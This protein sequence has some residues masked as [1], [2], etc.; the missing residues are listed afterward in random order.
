MQKIM[1]VE[2]EDDIVTLLQYNLEREGFEVAAETNGGRAVDA[3]AVQQPDL[4]LLDWMLP[5]KSGIDICREIRESND[6]RNI[7][8]I[9]LTARGEEADKIEGL[10]I[11]AD[12][13]MTK[14]FSVPE[15]VA[16]IRALL[17][18][19]RPTAT[20]GVLEFEDV[21]MDLATCRVTRGN[22]FVHLGPTEF[23]LL[24]FLMEKPRHVFPR[25][26]LL[27]EVWGA[28]IH[29]EL[30]TVDV[31]I[32]RLRKAMNDGGEK[33]LIRTIRAAGYSIDS[34]VPPEEA[35]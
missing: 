3:I 33:D 5:E 19:V 26:V 13:Y 8:I 34:N 30:R 21:K 7:P 24:Q 18:R 22:R 27:K 11:G 1:I 23:R 12:D 28:D 31:H 10:S 6:L 25:E 35:E 4:I 15:L 9:M 32:R 16:R 2:D 14:P 29:V 17:R 20:K